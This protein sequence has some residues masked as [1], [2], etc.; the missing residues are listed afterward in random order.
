MGK[1]RQALK[2]CNI[3][4]LNVERESSERRSACLPGGPLEVS[5]LENR[6]SKRKRISTPRPFFIGTTPQRSQ[7]KYSES[8][9]L[10]NHWTQE[11][12]IIMLKGGNITPLRSPVNGR[13]HL[14]AGHPTADVSKRARTRKVCPLAKEK[15]TSSGSE[16]PRVKRL[17]LGNQP[18]RRAALSPSP[19]VRGRQR[20][21]QEK[22]EKARRLKKSY[23]V[24]T[25]GQD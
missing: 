9:S 3:L 12:K 6:G 8:S 15:S 20:D 19:A 2:F 23:H 17:Q 4:H 16:V 7:T 11:R 21:C 24:F 18:S 14:D 13:I 25:K 22:E 10:E 1:G 5:D